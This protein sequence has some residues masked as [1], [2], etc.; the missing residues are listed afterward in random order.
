M[1]RWCISS[2]SNAWNKH[3]CSLSWLSRR[4]S[5]TQS[6]NDQST[7]VILLLITTVMQGVGIDQ[8]LERQ[9]QP[10]TASSQIWIPAGAGEEFSSP[11]ST[12][13]ADSYLG[14]CST[15]VWPQMHIKDPNHSAKSAGGRLQLNTHTPYVCGFAW[16][17]MAHSCMVYTEQDE[18]AAVSC[19]TSHVSAFCTAL[20]W[21]FKNVL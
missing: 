11:W 4:L 14:I 21:I 12:S 1:N 8:W 7:T 9:P 16:S 2:N 6:P 10:V 18:M 17:D 13:C 20:W 15:P 3:L 5:K 19:G